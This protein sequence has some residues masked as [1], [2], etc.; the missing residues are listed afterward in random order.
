M[1][2]GVSFK[3]FALKSQNCENWPKWLKASCFRLNQIW[4]E[5]NSDIY[6]SGYAWHNR[7]TYT[8]KKTH[9][10][11]E[12]AWGG[13]L[14][15]SLFD[16]KGNWHSIAVI[17][18]LDSHNNIEPVAGYTYLKISDL[19]SSFKIGG[20]YTLLVT[21]RPDLFNGYPFPGILPWV[22]L[23]YRRAALSATYI[24]G[25]K[26]SGNVLYIVGRIFLSI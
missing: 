15:K 26:N 3:G 24:P 5:G 18:F 2:N 4:T 17:A 16:E 20:G 19:S 14:G 1:Y 10:Y 9:T 23:F 12:L 22:S 7:F 8:S 21:A 25:S 13:G 6:L 11:N